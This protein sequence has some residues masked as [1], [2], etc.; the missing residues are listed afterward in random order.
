MQ[1]SET[2]VSEKMQ[3]RKGLTITL[4]GNGA[5]KILDNPQV[6]GVV[7][8]QFDKYRV[9]NTRK[10]QGKPMFSKVIIIFLYDHSCNAQG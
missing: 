10:A 2:K 1:A 4:P 9:L 7:V 3:I 6:Q 5:R 8:A